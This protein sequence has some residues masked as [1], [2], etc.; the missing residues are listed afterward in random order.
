MRF[1]EYLPI[2]EEPLPICPD[3]TDIAISF[4]LF[5]KNIKTEEKVPKELSALQ[6][7]H[8]AAY[9]Y[10]QLLQHTNIADCG[11]VRF[12]IDK[13]SEHEMRPYFKKIGLDA[14]IEIIDVPVG[15]R[16]SGYIPQFSHP[17]VN[18][19]RYRF[20][21]DVDLWWFTYDD[22]E[23]KFDWHAFCEYLDTADEDSFFGQPIQKQDWIYQI[24]YARHVLREDTQAKAL[25]TLQAIFG[26]RIPDPF[27]E[28]AYTQ[29]A[30][31]EE[32]NELSDFRCFA[33]WFVGVRND[34]IPLWYLDKFYHQYEKYLSDDEGLYS[35]LFYL[36]PEL[37]Q[38]QVLQGVGDAKPNEIKQAALSNWRQMEGV[39]T[40]N[41]GAS[42]FYMDEYKAEMFALATHLTDQEIR[43]PIATPEKEILPPAP[44]GLRTFGKHIVGT[45]ALDQHGKVFPLISH[46]ENNH[47]T[48][49]GF[50]A[51]LTPI[52]QPLQN[53]RKENAELAI[54][55]CLFYHPLHISHDIHIYAKSMVYAYKQL[56]RHT[57]IADVGSVYLFIDKR[58]LDIVY[59]Y[60]LEASIQ[61]LIVPFDSDKQVQYAAYIPHFW[62]EA[63][64]D[65]RYRFYMDVDM[66][67]INLINEDKFDYGVMI[68]VLENQNADVFGLP[69]PKDTNATAGDLYKRSV[70]P[71]DTHIEQTK[72][73]MRENFEAEVPPDEAIRA[74]SGCHN[75]IRQSDTLN[76]LRNFYQEVSEFIRD[77]EALWTIFL[78]KF[79][80]IGVKNIADVISGTGFSHEEYKHHKKAELAHVGT[81]MFE[82]F[83][84]KPYAE[85]LYNHCIQNHETNKSDN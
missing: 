49:F 12:F 45:Y 23:D 82:H 21:Q 38:F 64:E 71:E 80:D 17:A 79:N 7:A 10:R 77:D 3:G 54:I 18:E 57:N 8:E 37:K 28:I 31:L 22:S 33:G 62:H 44:C 69:V 66:W 43:E 19:C 42:E 29:N 67:W 70:L 16:L 41:V 50:P 61:K 81:Y 47:A 6:Y 63:I 74:I 26:P 2:I 52:K 25:E 30:I 24:N 9:A 55:Y 60:C 14:L 36:Y 51:A 53:A 58:I 65:V 11:R 56:I 15:V 73:W 76:I 46:T 5:N 27:H 68:E 32:R 13:R 85:T 4:Y 59:P 78:T 35:L 1:I 83:F 72:I 20:H 48:L 39:G 84:N 75:G 34:S 40:I